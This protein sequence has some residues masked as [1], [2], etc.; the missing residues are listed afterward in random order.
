MLCFKSVEGSIPGTAV[1]WRQYETKIATRSAEQTESLKKSA[2]ASQ[3]I[4]RTNS[5][6]KVT[7]LCSQLLFNSTKLLQSATCSYTRLSIS[8]SLQARA[9]NAGFDATPMQSRQGSPQRQQLPFADAAGMHFRLYPCLGQSS[10]PML[11]F[12]PYAACCLSPTRCTSISALHCTPLNLL[13]MN[14]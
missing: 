10:V 12:L 5:P 7:L 3:S 8:C 13:M 14:A 4:N 9:G 2:L 6:N 1:Q 11:S